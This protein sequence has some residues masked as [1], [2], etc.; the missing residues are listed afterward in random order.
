M[1]SPRLH[2]GDSF[3][4]AVNRWTRGPEHRVQF[5][6]SDDFLVVAMGDFVARAIRE[7]HPLVAV[8]TEPHRRAIAERLKAKGFDVAHVAATGQLT[9]VD[10]RGALDTFVVGSSLDVARCK[11]VA[12]DLLRAGQSRVKPGQMLHLC[13]E[14]VDLLCRDGNPECAVQLEQM[15][16]ELGLAHDFSMFCVYAMDTFHNVADAAQFEAICGEHT[17]VAPTER[18]MAADT[19]TLLHEITILEQRARAV[20]AEMEN[21]RELEGR[22][23][24]AEEALRVREQ[25]LHSLRE[26]HQRLLEST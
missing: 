8:T 24:L 11:A 4:R 18:Y 17:H 25:E 26:E 22:L 23:R 13:G 16:N 19:A 6:D 15:W 3:D 10:A 14:M 1:R 9:L 12:E 2:G 7:G 21:R 5:Y 20:E